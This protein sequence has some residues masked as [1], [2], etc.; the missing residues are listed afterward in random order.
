MRCWTLMT[1]L[2]LYSIALFNLMK[3]YVCV[4]FVCFPS[5]LAAMLGCDFLCIWPQK[6]HASCLKARVAC[7]E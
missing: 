7:S 2:A 1:V 5:S 4:M 6:T 3:I